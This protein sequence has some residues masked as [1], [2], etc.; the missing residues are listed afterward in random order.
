MDQFLS[1]I[2]NPRKT[3]FRMAAGL[4]GQGWLPAGSQRKVSEHLM[5]SFPGFTWR[6]HFIVSKS[7]ARRL[8]IQ[9]KAIL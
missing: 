3:C 9:M 4:P 7:E 6:I 1:G 2:S 5:P 8:L